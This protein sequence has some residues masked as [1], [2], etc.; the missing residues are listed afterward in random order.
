[1][2]SSVAHAPHLPELLRRAAGR[3]AVAITENGADVTYAQLWSGVRDFARTLAGQG[4]GPGSRVLIT[5]RGAL[6]TALSVYAVS[7]LGATASVIGDRYSDAQRAMIEADFAP[8]LILTEHD[9]D[10][11]TAAGPGGD[12][13]Q[14]GNP[15]L[16]I[17]T[18]GS[19]G[20]PGGVVCQREAVSFSVGAIQRVLGYRP[21][22][23]V[24][25][26]PPFSFDYGLYQLFLAAVSGASLAVAVP[27]DALA[28]FARASSLRPTVLPVLPA[29]ARS[30]MSLAARWPASVRDGVRLITSTGAHW[31]DDTRAA[32]RDLFPNTGLVSMYGLTECKRATISAVDEDLAAPGTVGRPLPGTAVWIEG[33]D[34]RPAARGEIGQVI[35]RGPHV[36]SG[37]WND[38]GRTR[39]TFRERQGIREL[40]TGDDGHFDA[41]GRL[42]VHGRRDGQVK[43]RG[44]RVSAAEIERAAAGLETVGAAALV[45]GRAGEP[46]LYVEGTAT[47]ADVRR[48]LGELVGTWKVPND[49]RVLDRLPV[50][51]RGKVDLAALRGLAEAQER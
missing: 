7:C 3:H 1:M 49:I 10:L 8:Q 22:D 17:Y 20:R 30:C 37:Y 9:G 50:N 31:D 33:A 38:P 5:V 13:A 42:Y 43:I 26:I 27:G 34:G 12:A 39:A 35:V 40:V 6:R 19:S 24:L 18:S 16:V 21:G 36:M 45:A 29:L 44:T 46:V 41:E 14:A 11:V 4:I 32:L 28:T 23:R 25:S 51:D 47:R 15:A 2:L 48:H